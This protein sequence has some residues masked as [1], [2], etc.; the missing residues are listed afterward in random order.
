MY[1]KNEQVPIFRSPNADLNMTLAMAL[2]VVVLDS[3]S[4][5]VGRATG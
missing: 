5:V 4:L 1:L 3:S 2:I